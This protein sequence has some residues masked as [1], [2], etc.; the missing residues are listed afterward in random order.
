MIFKAKDP[1]D[2]LH[3]ITDGAVLVSNFAGKEL[4]S[5]SKGAVFG[6]FI[7]LGL[8][9]HRWVSVGPIIAENR[10]DVLVTPRC[11][12]C[13]RFRWHRRFLCVPSYP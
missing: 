5:Y 7:P 4:F 8:L 12:S 3:I 13:C 2:D 10:T 6:E 1:G 9:T 11:A